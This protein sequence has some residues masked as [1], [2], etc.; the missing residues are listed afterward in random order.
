MKKGIVVGLWFWICG[1]N[2]RVV[3]Q[4]DKVLPQ[5]PSEIK[6]AEN[7]L[8]DFFKNLRKVNKNG[9]PAGK[10]DELLKFLEKNLDL[11]WITNFILGKH[12]KTI[13][14]QQKNDFTKLYSRYLLDSYRFA[15]DIYDLNNY[16][17]VAVE[18]QKDDVFLAKTTVNYNGKLIKSNFRL[19]FDAKTYHIT[20]I[21]TEGISFIAGKRA[22]L[23]ALV[24]RKGIEGFFRDLEPWR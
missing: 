3:A 16:E 1:L 7:F 19:V 18:K 24:A 12:C 15:F 8:R 5:K 6:G 4:P 23:N 13:S 2:S 20:D 14:N 21:V 17:L 9:K 10:N 22:E 11:T